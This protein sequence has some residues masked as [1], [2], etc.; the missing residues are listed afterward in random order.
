MYNF[1]VLFSQSRTTSTLR[2]GNVT[3]VINHIHC[4]SVFILWF[5]CEHAQ[6]LCVLSV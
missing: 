4:F 1:I 5:C 2:G 6:S 3:V